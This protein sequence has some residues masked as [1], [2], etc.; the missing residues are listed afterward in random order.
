MRPG[1]L[2]VSGPPGAAPGSTALVA[3]PLGVGRWAALH[4][5]GCTAQNVT[6]CLAVSANQAAVRPSLCAG[7]T[8][9]FL[10]RAGTRK[11]LTLSLPSALSWFKFKKDYNMCRVSSSA[12]EQRA[13]GAR[14]AGRWE[15]R[16]EE[17]LGM[18]CNR[19]PAKCSTLLV[20][21]QVR[22]LAPGDKAEGDP[23]LNSFPL[24]PAALR[25]TSAHR[26]RPELP[27]VQRTHL[28][29]VQASSGPAEGLAATPA[30]SLLSSAERARLARARL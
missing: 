19:D 10:A 14:I 18:C 20:I 5:V 22:P 9:R 23:S 11:A 26:L 6:F 1:A 15:G 24:L 8:G 4:C 28:P 29:D 25:G 13:E 27:A 3:P 30:C 7:G 12:R 2:V 16:P 21:A 17:G